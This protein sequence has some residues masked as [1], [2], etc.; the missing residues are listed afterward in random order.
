[1]VKGCG[2]NLPPVDSGDKSLCYSV[3]MRSETSPSKPTNDDCQRVIR[4]GARLLRRILGQVLA[5]RYLRAAVSCDP[6]LPLRGRV[7]TRTR[8][9]VVVVK[10]IFRLWLWVQASGVEMPQH[11]PAKRCKRT[12]KPTSPNKGSMLKDTGETASADSILATL[13][14]QGFR[15]K[16]P[17]W[18]APKRGHR[19][20][21][22]RASAPILPQARAWLLGDT[23]ILQPIPVSRGAHMPVSRRCDCGLK[24][25]QAY[26]DLH[27]VAAILAS[28]ERAITR[29]ARH[30]HRVDA[31]RAAALKVY[32]KPPPRVAVP[33]P[34]T[35]SHLR[36]LGC[37]R[38]TTQW[39]REVGFEGIPKRSHP[40]PTFSPSDLFT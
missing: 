8:A 21:S 28:P 17:L 5:C 35:I 15:P 31:K 9:G 25:G 36:S 14:A 19:V 32:A 23:D 34:P 22:G 2:Q 20:V 40:P 26:A 10:R 37:D 11:S 12:A 38:R 39:V 13:A 30:R 1:M 27:Y 29:L 18:D 3:F 6:N 16:V 24:A 4:S 7:H 33:T